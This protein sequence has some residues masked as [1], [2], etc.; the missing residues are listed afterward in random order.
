LKKPSPEEISVLGQEL[1]DSMDECMLCPM[2]CGANRLNG[3]LGECLTGAEP[4]VASWDFHFG[5]E[6]PLVGSGGSGTIFMAN[7]NLACKYCQN[8]RFSQ[9]GEGS[10]ITVER[11]AEIMLELQE[12]EATN[13]NLVTPSHQVAVI[14]MAL[15]RARKAGLTI[16]VVY[17]CSGYEKEEIIRKLAG[18]IDIYLVDMR[19][20]SDDVAREFSGCDNYVATNRAAVREM[21][22][23]VGDLV[24]NEEGLAIAGLMVRH[25]VLPGGLSG[26]EGIFR[27]LAQEISRETSVSLM[28]QYHPA[29]RALNDKRINRRITR[30]EFAK[31]KEAFY[32]AGLENGYIQD[33][34]YEKV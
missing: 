17:N 5:E 20:N 2:E 22:R 16:P 10:E 24:T 15:G 18:I 28:S 29:Y 34:W 32:E 12:T 1:Y 25:L 7:C 19:Y 33:L 13:I 9:E 23:Q 11:L 3:E 4:F 14:L 8:Y 6:P 21:Y 31:A 26:S 30:A 27:F